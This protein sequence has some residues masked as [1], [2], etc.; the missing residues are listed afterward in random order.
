MFIIIFL[1]F[2]YPFFKFL[3]A[4]NAADKF[5]ISAIGLLRKDLNEFNVLSKIAYLILN[6][7]YI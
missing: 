4:E 3:I 7:L 5:T 6:I 1:P 2:K